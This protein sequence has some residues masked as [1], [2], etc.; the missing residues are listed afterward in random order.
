MF[1]RTAS[2]GG[3][4]I[5][6]LRMKKILVLTNVYPASDLPSTATPVVHYFVKEWIPMGYDVRVVHYKSA[7]PDLMVKMAKFLM[8]FIKIN[9]TFVLSPVI[10]RDREYEIDGVKVKRIMIPKV[11]PHTLF[12]QKHV[13]L[14][15]EKTTSYLDGES[16]VPDV[17]LSHWANPQLEI[18]RTL[19]KKYDCRTCYIAHSDKEINVYG[20]RLEPLLNDIDLIGFRSDYICRM[21]LKTHKWDK[22]S[23][24]CYSGIPESFVDPNRKKT[25]DS[26]KNFVYVGT[27][28]SRKYPSAIIPSLAKVYGSEDFSLSYIGEGNE[29]PSI[30]KT[31]MACGV[32]ERVHLLGRIP[33]TKVVEQLDK[34]DVFVMI[35]KGETFGLVYL[36]AMARGCITIASKCEGFD[37][38]IQNGVNGF[39]CEAGNSDELAEIIMKIRNLNEDELQRISDNAIKTSCELTDVRAAKTYIENIMKLSESAYNQ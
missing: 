32:S 13:S 20:N 8:K 23:F 25:F 26:I 29:R 6:T 7:F 36:E 9:T 19:K 22:P 38:I 4:H 1:N 18:M 17:I 2:R 27:L 14:A 31:A 15:I 11:R 24:Y 37:G 5:T 30:E 3:S 21:F 10:V 28:I 34:N 33:R 35:S 12:K 39:L 16:F